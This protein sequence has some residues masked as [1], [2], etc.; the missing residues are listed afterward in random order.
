MSTVSLDCHSITPSYIIC[1]VP[2]CQKLFF[3]LFIK[4]K[5]RGKALFAGVRFAL[6]S[7]I[8]STLSGKRILSADCLFQKDYCIRANYT[9]VSNH[10]T[11]IFYHQSRKIY[12]FYPNI[13]SH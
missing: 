5:Y 9:H 3:Y 1:I 13:Q 10:N 8:F 6:Q 11:E 12:H 4:D 7:T 2:N